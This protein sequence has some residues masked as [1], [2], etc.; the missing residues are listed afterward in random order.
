LTSWIQTA[1]CGLQK[2]WVEM[3][4]NA[5]CYLSELNKGMDG[6]FA[7]LDKLLE[8]P[9]LQK[10]G[11]EVLKANLREELGNVNTTVLDVLEQSERDAAYVAYKQRRE[12]EKATRDPDDCYLMVMEREKELAEQGQP[13][14]IKVMFGFGEMTR[15]EIMNPDFTGE[16]EDDEESEGDRT[17]SPIQAGGDHGKQ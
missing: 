12:Y 9:E 6:V 1:A 8:Y 13:S 11:F 5:I 16:A 7:M 3:D 15:E 14:Q 10:D 4:R 2:G 17:Q